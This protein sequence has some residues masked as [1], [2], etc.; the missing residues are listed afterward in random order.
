M[1][2]LEQE[3]TGKLTTLLNIQ[4]LYVS[5]SE[6]SA[7]LLIVLEGNKKI[8]SKGL[9]SKI[10]QVLQEQPGLLYRIFTQ[11][12][13]EEQLE[14]GNLFFI[15]H[16]ILARCIYSLNSSFHKMIQV[17]DL[18]KLIDKTEKLIG[19]EFQKAVDFS[20]GANF[21]MKK[22]RY[23]K[24]VF[25]FHQTIELL[26]RLAEKMYMGECKI[27]HR[28]SCHIDYIKY[29]APDLGLLFHPDQEKEQELLHLLDRAYSDSRYSK[30]YTISDQELIEIKKK[31]KLMVDSVKDLFTTSLQTCSLK[32]DDLAACK[33][34]M[35]NR[36]EA[37]GQNRENI[38]MNGNDLLLGEIIN[39]LK[40]IIPLHSV[41]LIGKQSEADS[42]KVYLPPSHTTATSFNTYT[43]LVISDAPSPLSST[44]L[45]DTIYNR[46]QQRCKVYC[47]CYTYMKVKK[48]VNR[49]HNFLTRIIN[50]DRLLIYTKDS[51][52]GRLKY[53]RSLH[54][55]IWKH[56]CTQWETRYQKADYLYTI[57]DCHDIKQNP[58]AKIG[59]LHFALEQICLGLLY[60][61]W[62]FKPTQHTLSFLIHLCS[63]ITGL[64]EYLFAR[65]S[66]TSHHNYHL[67]INGHYQMRFKTKS[68]ITNKDAERLYECCGEF[69]AK[70]NELAIAELERLKDLHFVRKENTRNT[71]R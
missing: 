56:I 47:I 5:E 35:A 66:Y 12:Y 48:K 6:G 27:T 60:V 22:E 29:F 49:G 13:V 1:S 25:M 26:F 4:N 67:L 46:M 70:A 53:N 62:E 31:T 54:E 43:L 45:T 10:H 57:L 24:A 9:L 16:C 64:P 51:N 19:D 63:H 21:Y 30:D 52:I 7:L 32:I 20:E 15:Q 58:V 34:N 65:N 37:A 59:I 2:T 18:K 41:F 28:I 50:D 17:L 8:D 69:I 33:N 38:R 39:H 23:N 44:N 40:T 55:K 68:T 11:K 42:Q 61:F 14:I 36:P 3:I 71:L